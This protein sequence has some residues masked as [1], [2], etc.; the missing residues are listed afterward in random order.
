[1]ANTTVLHQLCCTCAR[2]AR[3]SGQSEDGAQRCLAAPQAHARTTLVSATSRA[4]RA[5]N[6]TP[7]APASWESGAWNGNMGAEVAPKTCPAHYR[8]CGGGASS[9]GGG[10]CPAE[11]HPEP[12]RH[13]IPTPS[14][15]D[16]ASSLRSKQL[17]RQAA[18]KAR[19]YTLYW[20]I[21]SQRQHP[22]FGEGPAG[23][24]A[25]NALPKRARHYCSDLWPTGWD[26]PLLALNPAAE[27]VR[28]RRVRTL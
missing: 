17:A 22:S 19:Q 3:W 5:A 28:L 2:D 15:A 7:P 26:D 1:M 16:N 4:L 27:R 18:G 25:R 6:G 21:A 10:M 9:N 24:P 11:L 8:A 13:A 12:R 23:L 14:P 20:G